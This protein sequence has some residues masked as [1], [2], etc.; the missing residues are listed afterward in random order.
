VIGAGDL[1]EIAGL[2]ARE[3]D[4]DLL[5]TLEACE[6]PRAL[7]LVAASLGPVDFV[8]VTAMERPREVFDACVQVFGGERV[9]APELLRIYRPPSVAAPNDGRDIIRAY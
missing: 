6:D 2:V 3:H 4:V 7:S 9:H 8:V 5:A 1:A